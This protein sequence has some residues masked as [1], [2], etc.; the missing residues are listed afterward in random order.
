MRK[1]LSDARRAGC[2]VGAAALTLI[3][4]AALAQI[5]SPP[6]DADPRAALVAQAIA[7]EHGEGVPKDPLLAA[8]LYCEAAR[9][10]DPE[11]QYALG[12]MYANGRGVAR[13]DDSA[14]A[15]FVLAARAG[16]QYAQR[17]L[18]SDDAPGKLPACMEELDPI[19]ML[20]VPDEDPLA[21]LLFRHQTIARL[22]SS[23]APRY[24]IDPRLAL[25]VIAVE[26]NFEP[27]ARSLKDARGLMQ[28]IPETAARFN[29]KNPFDVH[30]NVRGGL[31][32]LR[33]LLAYYQGRVELAAAAYNA[34][35]ATVDRYRGIP[36]Y[37]ETRDYV[38]RVLRLFRRESHPYDARVV[39]PS[40]MLA[41]VARP[42]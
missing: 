7:F 5:V 31:T 35:E 11:A 36:P 4:S 19:V 2:R 28:L 16:H 1:V 30:D 27:R 42:M 25:S 37:P 8:A 10:G 20:P 9:A 3:A 15:M 12:W 21:E 32:Y 33:W 13:D 29:V 18:G 34:G 17:M 40:P 39:S 6:P 24:G 41:R 14:R 38:K 22:V 26:S 23:V